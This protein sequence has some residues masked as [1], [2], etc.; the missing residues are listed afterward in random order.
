MRSGNVKDGS[1]ES[2]NGVVEGKHLGLEQVVAASRGVLRKVGSLGG[3]YTATIL[4]E[5]SVLETLGRF[6]EG[7]VDTSC[8][9]YL[10]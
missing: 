6:S 10:L 8:E 2:G 5:R 4:R 7:I 9:A 1:S 3:V